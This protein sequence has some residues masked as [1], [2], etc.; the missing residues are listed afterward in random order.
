MRPKFEAEGSYRPKLQQL[1]DWHF[2]IN[3][4]DV[5]GKEERFLRKEL[6]R[7]LKNEGYP[8]SEINHAIRK[9]LRDK[10]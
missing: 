7:F 10:P 5:G 8:A 2:F 1:V 3:H 6:K 4:Y 9:S